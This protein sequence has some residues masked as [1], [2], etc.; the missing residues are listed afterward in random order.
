MVKLPDGR[1]VQ[2]YLQGGAD[3]VVVDDDR[4]NNLLTLL[5]LEGLQHFAPVC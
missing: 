2:G 5:C 1:F 3:T 4:R